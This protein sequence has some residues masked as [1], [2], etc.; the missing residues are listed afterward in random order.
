MNKDFNSSAHGKHIAYIH[1]KDI[2]DLGSNFTIY[3][4]FLPTNCYIHDNNW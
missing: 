1:Q 4:L 3:S 2:A